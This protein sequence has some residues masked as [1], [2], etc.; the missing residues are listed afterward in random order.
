MRSG[1][2]G[3]A[4]LAILGLGMAMSACTGNVKESSAGAQLNNDDYY[5]AHHDGRIYVFDD[6][7]SYLSFLGMGETPYTLVRIGAGPKGQTVV[8]GLRSK[9]KKKRSG[10]A[11]VDMYDGKLTPAQDFYGEIAMEG[12]YYV[13]D[14]WA[15]LQSF[16]KVG[17]ATFRYTDI[18]GGP[19]GATVVY[20]LNKA[21]KKHRPDGL[22]AKFKA[23]HA[24]S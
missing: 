5:E 2:K 21:N 22:I 4:G 13:F 23:Q 12:R 19:G 18:G 15:D 20:V 8:F 10:I 9:D 14:H 11:S 3:A 6:A 7:K 24:D 1:I 16:K 17:E